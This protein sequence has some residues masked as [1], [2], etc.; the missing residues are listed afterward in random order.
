[1]FV[2][3]RPSNLDYLT[4]LSFV[5]PG[6]EDATTDMTISGYPA[7]FGI[8]YRWRLVVNDTVKI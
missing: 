3:F 4:Y 7:K 1:M 5:R 8:R 2:L 6:P